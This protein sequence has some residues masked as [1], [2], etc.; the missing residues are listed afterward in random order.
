MTRNATTGVV[1]LFV[2]GGLNA[3][4]VLDTGNKT[5]P[6]KLIGALSDVAA[7]GVT[8]TGDNYFN[9]QID[10]VRIYNQ[11]LGLSEV[12]G[13]ALLPAAPTLLTATPESGPVV[14]LTFSNPSGYAQNIEIDRK[15]GVNGTYAPVTTVSASTTLYDDTNVVAGTSYYYVLKA[16]D[17]VGA[18]ALSNV[19]SVTPPAPSIVA[20]VIFYNNSKFDGQNGSSNI[21]DDVAIAPD[22]QALLPGG[23]ATYANYTD[24]SKGIN[25][26]MIDVAN[27]Q[28]LPRLDDFEF[29][30]GNDNNPADWTQAP[31]PTYVNSYPGRGPG[32]STQITLIWNDN[33]IENEWLQVTML[34]QPHLDLLANDVFYFGNA[35]GDTG[36]SSTDALTTPNDATRISNNFT[37]SAPLSDPYDLNRDG[38][39]DSTDVAIANANQTTAE[40]AL[41]LISLT[42][43]GTVPTVATPASAHSPA[44]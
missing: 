38:V 32:G 5:S 14:H 44:P 7:D 2:D 41:S 27:L 34:A 16:I 3:T 39:V 23:T 43:A 12:A 13:L 36:D 22:K 29:M 24:Y 42:A 30:V 15:I 40:T 26:I 21:S 6:F 8:R 37:A 19:L 11:V 1:Q 33:A 17:L 20:N 28:N 25:G 10:E 18:S 31:T 9:G 35:I 4:A